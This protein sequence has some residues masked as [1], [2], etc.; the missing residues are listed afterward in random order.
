M[1]WFI[2]V[3][4]LL[5]ILVLQS[6]FYNRERNQLINRIIAKNVEEMK[7]LESKPEKQPIDDGDM[8]PEYVAMDDMN[9]DDFNKIIRQNLGR[10]TIKDKAVRKLKEK[11]RGNII[12]E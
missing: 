7:F 4:L 2:L 10:E 5:G 9:T 8:P 12:S 6:V 3:V 1:E 11:V